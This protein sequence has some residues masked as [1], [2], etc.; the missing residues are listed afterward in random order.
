M[1]LGRTLSHISIF[2]YEPGFWG[3]AESERVRVEDELRSALSG[4][5]DAVHFY[6]T[7]ATRAGSDALVWSSVKV[8][9]TDAP[10]RFFE[11]F[12]D[13]LRPFRNHVR[14]VDALW[15]L[16]GESEY[17]RRA[18]E[19]AI[20]PFQPRSRQYLVVYPFAKT[21]AWYATDAEER[22]GMMAEHIRV[23]L[24]HADIEQ[25]LLYCT[26]LQDHEFVVVYETDDLAAFTA[27]VSELRRTEGRA[28]TL[29]DSPVHVGIHL[30][31]GDRA[32][33]RA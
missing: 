29:L 28:Y 26:G 32:T 4:A 18:S 16:T 31:S 12:S 27:L 3:L 5:A 14:L 30:S 9:S 15:G 24:S 1:A 25:Q 2:S 6:R 13:S 7:S 8:V 23:G 10:A 21:H 17:S 22:R 20:D 19:R 11:N 33:E